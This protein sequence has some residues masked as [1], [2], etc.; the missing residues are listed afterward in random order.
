MS[1]RF[2]FLFLLTV[3][4]PAGKCPFNDLTMKKV[5]DT[6]SGGCYW[7]GRRGPPRLLTGV[8]ILSRDLFGPSF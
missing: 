2:D 5:D 8:N 7:D 4:L 1:L 3:I 6:I